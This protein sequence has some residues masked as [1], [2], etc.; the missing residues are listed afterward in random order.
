MSENRVIGINNSLPWHLSD[1]L[2]RFKSLTTNHSVI[3]GRKTFESIGK[4]LPNRRNI[5]LS[6][7]KNLSFVGAKVINSIEDALLSSED[8]K[9]LF[10]IGGEKIYS[11]FLPLATHMYITRIHKKFDGD[12]FF[13][14]F[15]EKEWLETFREDLVSSK[16]LKF[17]FQNYKKSD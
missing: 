15:E 3:M 10:I 5:V 16:W 12:A 14:Y 7:N 6:N 2:K 1:D 9:E 17:S 11:S 8:D 4:P 13:P